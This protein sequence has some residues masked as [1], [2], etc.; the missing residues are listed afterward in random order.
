VFTNIPGDDNGETWNRVEELTREA[1]KKY[2]GIEGFRVERCHRL[3]QRAGSGGRPRRVIVKFSFYKDR[4][5]VLSQRHKFKGSNIYVDPDLP[6]ELRDRR[7]ALRR[8]VGAVAKE[9]GQ[10]IAIPFPFLRAQVGPRF[11]SLDQGGNLV[12]EEESSA[13]GDDPSRGGRNPDGKRKRTAL[14]LSPAPGDTGASTTRVQSPAK[15]GR[16]DGR[17]EGG[18]GTVP[19]LD[20]A[21]TDTESGGSA[22][23]PR[24]SV[25]EEPWA[26]APEERKRQ[27]KADKRKKQLEG[28]SRSKQ[29]QT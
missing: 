15:Q 14:E 11:F 4:D 8:A 2:I 9:E 24:S 23:S 10:R 5:A 28:K 25:E 26:T 16:Q 3:G 27:Q 13:G 22:D 29:T 17:R 1:I 19:Q 20:G 18:T 7:F 12:E 21:A 6:R